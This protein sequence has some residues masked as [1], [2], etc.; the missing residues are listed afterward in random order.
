MC[1]GLVRDNIEGQK[2]GWSVYLGALILTC[3]YVLVRVGACVLS[4]GVTGTGVRAPGHASHPD[5]HC[6]T[7]TLGF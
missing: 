4:D 6:P 1:I 3:A 5:A 7:T 2:E